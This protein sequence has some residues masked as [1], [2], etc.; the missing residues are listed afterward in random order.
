MGSASGFY[1]SLQGASN[2]A[3]GERIDAFAYYLTEIAGAASATAAKISNCFRD[4]D[5]AVPASISQYLSKGLKGKPPKYVKVGTGGYRL[6][7]HARERLAGLIGLETAVLDIPADLQRLVDE[8][9]EGARKEFLR[10][11]LA[12]FGVH[13]YRATIIM[14]WLLTL[15]H[16][17]E[18]ILI[19]HQ[20]AF[21]KALAANTDKRVKVTEV[22]VRD[23]FGEMPENKFIEFCR[24]AGVVSNDVRKI[25][26]EKLGTRNS[27]AHPSGVVFSR[28]KVV[29]FVED[30]FANVIR[31]YPLK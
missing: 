3:A 9:P 25:L 22:A 18:L 28:A 26:D 10:E 23:D 11:A 4:C 31:K 6:E 30:L 1:S 5:L 24:S 17:F 7:R 2:L 14:A 20:D 19:K 21:N 15:D 12:C 29:A 16:L 27:A 13:A 8:L